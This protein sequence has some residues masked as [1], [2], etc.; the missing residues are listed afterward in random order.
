MEEVDETVD[1]QHMKWHLLLEWKK[2]K[3]KIRLRNTKNER[4][5]AHL[6]NNIIHVSHWARL[7]M[8][9]HRKVPNVKKEPQS[10]GLSFWTKHWIFGRSN[11]AWLPLDLSPLFFTPQWSYLC[12]LLLCSPWKSFPSLPH[13]N[14][15]TP[16]SCLQL[17]ATPKQYM[18]WLHCADWPDSKSNQTNAGLTQ[19]PLH[20]CGHQSGCLSSTQAILWHPCL[21]IKSSV[22]WQTD[23]L[24]FMQSR[25][26]L[27]GRCVSLR[28]AWICSFQVK[29]LF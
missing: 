1:L 8:P 22:S 26:S 20:Q 7:S 2:T 27:V 16:H 13:N 28:V 29:L 6:Q 12:L 17:L 19:L 21:S 25:C 3:Q 11:K 10:P 24:Y 14:T 18:L 5:T 23:W 4:E 15:V 9:I